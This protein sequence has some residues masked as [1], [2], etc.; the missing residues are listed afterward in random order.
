MLLW[1]LSKKGTSSISTCPLRLPVEPCRGL[2]LTVLLRCAA[3]GMSFEGFEF[4]H[5][6]ALINSRAKLGTLT[7]TREQDST[8]H[9]LPKQYNGLEM[10]RSFGS[11]SDCNP[12]CGIAGSITNST[13]CTG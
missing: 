9:L 10:P 2:A 11:L 8:V 4:L 5:G 12:P 1:N 6:C 3:V 13:D 7:L